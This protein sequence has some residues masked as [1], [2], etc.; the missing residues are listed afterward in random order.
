MKGITPVIAVILLLL[1]TIAIIGF[2]SVFFQQTV[3]TG[4]EQAQ[5]AAAGQANKAL[6]TAEI[7][8]VSNGK[9]TIKN[10]G[11]EPI[12]TAN[13]QIF[14]DGDPAAT[15]PVG[16]AENIQPGSTKT[17]D[18]AVPPGTGERKI[19]VAVPGNVMEKT[20][21]LD[22]GTA[23]LISAEGNVITL[24]NSGVTSI[25]DSEISMKVDGAGVTFT[26]PASLAA[27][28][29]GVYTI[30]PSSIPA[31][32]G[33]R[34]VE[35]RTPESVHT[36]DADIN[37][38]TI[39]L[40]GITGNKLSIKNTGLTTV[41]KDELILT[42]AGQGVTFTGPAQISPDETVEYAVNEI[43]ILGKEGLGGVLSLQS[44]AS[45]IT[46]NTAFD[47]ASA[48]KGYWKFDDLDQGK[49][50]KDSSGNGMDG[51]F[52]GTTH[53]GTI[54]TGVGSVTA[55]G[56]Y[57]K[58]L[59][60]SAL[61]SSP[62]AMNSGN[63][64]ALGF[65]SGSFS[66]GI[67][68]KQNGGGGD[69][70]FK[71]GT[72]A[73]TRVFDIEVF[74]SGVAVADISNGSSILSA[75]SGT[76]VTD[77]V[78]HHIFVV[79]D[80]S[81]VLSATPKLYIFI[82]GVQKGATNILAAFGSVMSSSNLNF[83]RS[84]DGF[85]GVIDEA[86]F[87]GRALTGS[88]VSADMNSV[89]PLQGVA[90]SY[91]FESVTGT[92]V[93]DTHFIVRG[94]ND[95]PSDSDGALQMNGGSDYV[96]INDNPSLRGMGELTMSALVN[97]SAMAPGYNGRIISTSSPGNYDWNLQTANQKIVFAV[98]NAE[99]P[100]VGL[101]LTTSGSY[102]INT[103]NNILCTYNKNIASGNMKCYIDGSADSVTATQTKNVRNAATPVRLGSYSG[104]GSM[105]GLFDEARIMNRAVSKD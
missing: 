75:S 84:G 31:G 103:W 28:A 5:E 36:A 79:V 41:A 38:G 64:S 16:D 93:I 17:F 4:G 94:N 25:Q 90:V 39:S 33:T 61:G 100:S 57:G 91:S 7:V 35:I 11:T 98:A 2:T 104:S 97:P 30:T 53:D 105:M 13:V 46:D 88:E 32:S 6:Q 1:I 22:A 77:N 34:A 70:I 48:T 68:M 29:E 76:V 85:S 54:N 86:R 66:Y 74:G 24:K 12:S 20:F 51:T 71:G 67:W 87:Y 47:Y 37:I 55:S 23:D 82:D 92:A 89:Y 52:V 95:A 69:P 50:I 43:E 73:V 72:S 63:P 10:V 59:S 83:P 45:T 101:S 15:T 81:G 9:V 44:L 18:I 78:W 62:P 14:V 26:G 96:L 102:A 56:K 42:V 40:E 8:D 3:T 80:R 19:T 99:L 60:I 49:T 27:G 65:G 58:G 21:Q